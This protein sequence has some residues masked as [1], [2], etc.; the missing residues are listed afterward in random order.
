MNFLFLS[1]LTIGVLALI[2]TATNQILTMSTMII[3]AVG[4]IAGAGFEYMVNT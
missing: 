3:M 1:M 2:L 4:L